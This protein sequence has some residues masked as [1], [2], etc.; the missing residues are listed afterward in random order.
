[1]AAKC[2]LFKMACHDW[3]S[4]ARDV[5]DKQTRLNFENTFRSC[6]HPAH[7][8]EKR[9]AVKSCSGLHGT[10]SSRVI[11]CSRLAAL[12]VTA[13]DIMRAFSRW[14]SRSFRFALVSTFLAFHPMSLKT[15]LSSPGRRNKIPYAAAMA[16][17]NSEHRT[18]A[19][20]SK[21]NKPAPIN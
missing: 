18:D 6:P 4:M 9:S 14:Y 13:R 5:Q 3:A 7:F 17:A 11:I 8:A 10:T 12:E 2:V 19:P 1:M 21:P 16:T 20:T 15:T